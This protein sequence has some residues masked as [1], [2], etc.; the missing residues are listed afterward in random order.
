MAWRVLITHAYRILIKTGEKY[1]Q[2]PAAVI[3]GTAV[4]GHPQRNGFGPPSSTAVLLS[5][6]MSTAG[7]LD[8]EILE[9]RNRTSFIFAALWPAGCVA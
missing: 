3:Q 4:T 1:S 8:C 5:T 2:G 7:I 6:L 9:G